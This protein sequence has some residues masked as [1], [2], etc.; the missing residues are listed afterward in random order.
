[1]IASVHYP[2]YCSKDRCPSHLTHPLCE[3]TI[4]YLPTYL[5]I[6]L[7][8]YLPIYLSIYLFTYLLY[9]KGLQDY[10]HNPHPKYSRVPSIPQ[11]H[12]KPTTHRTFDAVGL[13]YKKILKQRLQ[14]VTGLEEHNSTISILCQF[15]PFTWL[16]SYLAT[17]TV[18]MIGSVMSE[19]GLL[20]YLSSLST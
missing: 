5:S 14:R 20:E 19:E 10:L 15:I 11:P 6:Y 16:P 3:A 13:Y 8:T 9:K 4:S 7:P 2:T 12:A 1:M 17:S 18:R